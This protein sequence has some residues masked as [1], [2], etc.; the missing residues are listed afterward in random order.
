VRPLLQRGL[1]PDV[2]VVPVPL[3]DGA[4]PLV[5]S[6]CVA[7]PLVPGV[8]VSGVVPVLPPVPVPEGGAVPVPPVPPGKVLLGFGLV[9]LGLVPLGSG[10]V[11]VLPPAALGGTGLGLVP[12]GLVPGVVAP[13][14]VP[15]PGVG[16]APPVVCA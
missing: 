3:G 1:V 10:L 13:G 8:V 7:P 5:E 4:L 2:P 9:P 6:G 16:P 14:L 15:V 12:I 11:P